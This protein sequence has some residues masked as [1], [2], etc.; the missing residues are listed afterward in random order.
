MKRNVQRRDEWKIRRGTIDV[1]N[2]RFLMIPF[3]KPP[4]SNERKFSIPAISTFDSTPDDDQ[5]PASREDPSP[6]NAI[7]V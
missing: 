4:A 6:T 7:P 1:L 2:S 3:D 5:S